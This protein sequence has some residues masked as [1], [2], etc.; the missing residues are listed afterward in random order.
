[1]GIS[2]INESCRDYFRG[3]KDVTSKDHSQVLKG[4][5]KIVSYALIFPP[6]IAAIAYGSTSLLKKHFTKID[7]DTSGNPASDVKRTEE[8]IEET[9]KERFVNDVKL[10]EELSISNWPDDVDI[11]DEAI[12]ARKKVYIVKDRRVND[13]FFIRKVS[14]DETS[15]DEEITIKID[16]SKKTFQFLANT[17]TIQTNNNETF[18]D[19]LL[20]ACKKGFGFDE[21]G[22]DDIYSPDYPE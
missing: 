2:S 18:L 5:A 20:D 11:G 19:R 22:E 4:I 14:S 16:E 8:V 3:F 1:M 15:F 7:V 10:L 17:T 9:K 13:H 21:L 6:V 12:K